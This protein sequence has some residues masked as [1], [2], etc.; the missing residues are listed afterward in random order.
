MLQQDGYRGDYMNNLKILFMGTPDFG[1]PALEELH[2]IYNIVGVVSQPDR[3]ANR[4]K[5]VYSPIKQFAI[6]NNI[7]VFQPLKL[8]EEYAKILETDPDI[9]ITCAYGQMLP[10]DFIKYPQYG[11]INIHASLLPKLRGGAPIQR[12]IIDGYNKTGITIMKTVLKMDAGDMISQEEIEITDD[13]TTGTLHDKLSV[14]AKDLIVKT[15]PDIINNKVVYKKQNEDEAT[16]AWN[17]KKEDEKINF[18]DISRKIIKQIKGLNPY[19][20]AY[21]ILSGKILKI[22]NAKEGDSYPNDSYING[23]IT[24]I[25]NDG[26]G[27]KTGNGELIVTEL[28]LEGRKKMT[29]SEFL[30]GAVNKDLL[31]GRILE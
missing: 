8:K 20:G 22:W 6:E 2:K 18:D 7:K 27:I 26:I 13:D 30:N 23:Q 9:I 15:L 5:I 14:L 12:A 11:C 16:Y 21:T 4:G 19:P 10:E 1:L 25:Y 31:V 28:Q 24:S 29:A 3:P 17:I